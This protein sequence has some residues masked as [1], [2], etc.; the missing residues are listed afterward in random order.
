MGR[1]V[2]YQEVWDLQRCLAAERASRNITD[3]LLLLEHTHV[4]TAGRRSSREH[5][6]LDAVGLRHLGVPLIETDRGGQVTYHG[7]GQLV[8][9]PVMDLRERGMGPRQYLRMLERVLVETL[10]DFG[11]HAHTEDDLTGV[12]VY[13]SKIAAIGVKVSRGVA[14]H[15]FALNVDPDLDYYRHIVPCGIADRDVTSMT[16]L[17]KYA[18]PMDAV[19]KALVRRFSACC[20]V[21]LQQVPASAL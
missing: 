16:R 3:T 6:L 8:G 4:Y 17:L 19:R 1:H 12:W 15:G 18:V 9:Y 10:T 14:F 20:G 11:I 21:T 13:G 5:V 7:P 2:D